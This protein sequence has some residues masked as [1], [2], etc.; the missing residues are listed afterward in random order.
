MK[1]PRHKPGFDPVLREILEVLEDRYRGRSCYKIDGYAWCLAEEAVIEHLKK[2]LDE[3]HRIR[4]T[5][6]EI[7]GIFIEDSP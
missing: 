2:A 7:D 5:F 6:K 3:A 1:R 4:A